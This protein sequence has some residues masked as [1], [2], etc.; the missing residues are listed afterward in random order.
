MNRFGEIYAL[1]DTLA[2]GGKETGI[3]NLAEL[4]GKELKDL[5]KHL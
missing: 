4:H 5:S 2:E 1:T 3:K